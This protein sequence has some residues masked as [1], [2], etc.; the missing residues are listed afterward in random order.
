M[1]YISGGAFRRSIESRLL[2][3]HHE[4]AVP[5][6]RM[7]KI[8]VFDRFLARLVVAYPGQW[9]L[10]GGYLM[11]LYF[12]ER[13][14]TTRDI[15]L[16]YLRESVDIHASL[17]EAG[18]VDLG[19]WFAFEVGT[20]SD[21][22]HGNSRQFR[23]NVRALLDSR[24]FDDFHLDI[25]TSDVL[26]GK[27]VDRQ[28]K[29]YL[30]FA[31]FSPALIPCYSLEQQIAEKLHSLT[32]PRGAEAVSRVKDLVDILFIAGHESFLFKRLDQ[33]IQKTFDHRKT[34]PLPA[35]FSGMDNRFQNSFETLAKETNLR[36]SLLADGIESASVFFEPVL[37][38]ISHAGHWD[39][40][41]W[42]WSSR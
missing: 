40:L 10:K 9:V 13:V 41:N 12:P 1:K 31:G 23:F 36:V 28:G 6:D 17:I 27:P 14:R 21:I 42:R 38:G 7:R 18:R 37:R 34:H 8:I 16:L 2:N 35:K 11:E 15:D 30:D 20:P 24:R 5:L 25:N 19:D 39:P 3:Y 4:A 29:K 22:S 26:I 32:L 33:A